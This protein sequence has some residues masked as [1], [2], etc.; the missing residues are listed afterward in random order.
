MRD[1]SNDDVKLPPQSELCMTDW[2]LRS[3]ETSSSI[4]LIINEINS[5]GLR[6]GFWFLNFA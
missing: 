4:Y 3:D 1:V 2:L 6:F 5:S